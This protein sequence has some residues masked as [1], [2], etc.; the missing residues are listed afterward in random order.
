MLTVELGWLKKCSLGARCCWTETTIAFN[1]ISLIHNSNQPLNAV[2]RMPTNN[3]PQIYFRK[4]L[5]EMI[6]SSS[7]RYLPEYF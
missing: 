5:L 1:R 6:V 4:L 2:M 7:S 3:V